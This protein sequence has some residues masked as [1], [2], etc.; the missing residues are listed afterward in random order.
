MKKCKVFLTKKVTYEIEFEK[1]E[2]TTNEIYPIIKRFDQ[3]SNE[4][5]FDLLEKDI[6]IKIIEKPDYKILL[7]EDESLKACEQIINKMEFVKKSYSYCSVGVNVEDF[8]AMYNNR[9]IEEAFYNILGELNI[10]KF[11]EWVNA[12]EE[13]KEDMDHSEIHHSDFKRLSLEEM[14][15]FSKMNDC[16]VAYNDYEIKKYERLKKLYPKCIALN[17]KN[18]AAMLT[19]KGNELLFKNLGLFNERMNKG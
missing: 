19:P 13:Y 8:L 10:P 7:E 15:L 9:L 18:R 1:N 2:I 5:S 6:K 3:E 14:K 4:K 11:R 12:Y 17:R 16:F